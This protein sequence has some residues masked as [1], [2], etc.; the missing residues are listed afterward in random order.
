MKKNEKSAVMWAA[1]AY[2]GKKENNVDQLTEGKAY[3][4]DLTVK[5]SIDG[6]PVNQILAG[7]LTV[8]HGTQ[9]VC[10][11]VDYTAVTAYLL[12][13]LTSKQRRQVMAELPKMLENEAPMPYTEMAEALLVAC[14]ETNKKVTAV[15]GA[16][17]F[18]Y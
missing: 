8:G 15:R 13:M 14:K 16:V 10:G 5:G 9:R 4:V 12:G 18:D 3:D 1:M 6:H 17:R 11:S 2:V 7:Q